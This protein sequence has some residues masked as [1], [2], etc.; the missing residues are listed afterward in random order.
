MSRVSRPLR[1]LVLFLLG[2]V[3]ILPLY[4]VL[5]NSAT[6]PEEYRKKTVY[7]VPS[8]FAFSIARAWRWSQRGE[9]N[10]IRP[11]SNC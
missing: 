4:L 11:S 8:H 5:I 7:S 2:A 3:W 1:Y 10:G 6:S 9:P